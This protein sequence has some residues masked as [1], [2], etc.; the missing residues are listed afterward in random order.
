VDTVQFKRWVLLADPERTAEAYRAIERS[1]AEVCGCDPCRN[2]LAQHEGIYPPDVR[3]L[4]AR[5]GMD[6]QREAEV[7][8]MARVGPGRHHYGG[9][10][11][12]VG[13]LKSGE[14]SKTALEDGATRVSFEEIT[15]AFAIAFTRAPDLVAP[16]FGRLP[17]LQLEFAVELPWVL[18]DAH[19][20]V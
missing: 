14:D 5:L 6:W 17:V 12:F 2:F 8:H 10:L 3:E 9:W 20:P 15:P 7:Y 19:E 4:F 16:S 18:G 1:A 11:H 13:D